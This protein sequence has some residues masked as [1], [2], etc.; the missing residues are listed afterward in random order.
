M[1]IHKMTVYPGQEIP[2]DVKEEVRSAAKRPIIFDDDTPELTDEQLAQFAVLAKKQR[3]DRKKSVLSL[4]ISKETLAKAK[5][6]GRGYT[7]VL[8]RLLDMAINDKEMV[9]KALL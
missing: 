3:D 2:K 5:L 8:S 9:K 1:A 4:R 6:L 7:G